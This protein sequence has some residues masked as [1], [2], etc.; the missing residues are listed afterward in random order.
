MHH[1]LGTVYFLNEMSYDHFLLREIGDTTSHR[2]FNAFI[3]I[4]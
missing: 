2:N 1:E 3:H 4:F